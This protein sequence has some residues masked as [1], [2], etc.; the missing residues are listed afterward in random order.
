MLTHSNI[1]SNVIDAGEKYELFGCGHTAVG[2]A[3]LARLRAVGDVPLHP[4][5]HGRSLCRIDRKGAGQSTRGSADNLCRR[6]ADIRKGLCKGETESG[7]DRR[8]RRKRSLTGRS[9]KAKEHALGT[10]NETPVSSCLPIKHESADKLV[11]SKLREFF[12]GR[13][14]FLHHRRVRHYRTRYIS[15]SRVPGFR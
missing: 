7:T 11:F 12:G 10:A 15:S 3:A 4:Q 14:P 1:I 8:R 6:T 5:R 2:A 9:S 13:S